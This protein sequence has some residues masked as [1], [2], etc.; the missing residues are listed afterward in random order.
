[1]SKAE[2]TPITGLRALH[3][4]GGRANDG[5]PPR[6]FAV[7]H[8]PPAGM[9]V[10]GL[11]LHAHA[12]AEEMNKSRHMVAA[13]ARGLAAAGWTVLVPDLSGCGDSEGEFSDASWPQWQ[14]DLV[15]CIHWLRDLQPNMPVWLWGHRAGALL[16]AELA[17]RDPA[18]HEAHL[19]FWQPVV[20]G[21]L[22][23]QQ[24]LRLKLAA[25]LADG[26]AP[27][28]MMEGVKAELAA[29]GV[30]EV[31]G[32]A[33]PVAVTKGLETALLESPAAT[34]NGSPR[35]LHWIEV[36][37]REPAALLPASSRPLQAFRE[38]GWTVQAEAVAG[39]GF[40][41]TVEIES[42]PALLAATLQ[43]LAATTPDL[44]LA[45]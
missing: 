18:A 5:P 32:Y 1:V 43:A 24:F 36:A 14:A 28:G 9:P 26:A 10:R 12:F 8:E 21:S 37:S 30:L 4:A 13:A 31:A 29:A 39:P 45:A 35:R 25:G 15:A 17:A 44:A 42:A 33:L 34:V 41:Q 27:K 3:L 22:H 40:W 20:R 11:V 6:L 23:L 19:L 16:A 38:A 7:L 2:T